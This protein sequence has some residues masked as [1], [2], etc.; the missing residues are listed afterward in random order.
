[1]TE[2]RPTGKS[3]EA[4]RDP[5]PDGG[6]ADDRPGGGGRGGAS[7]A[8]TQS[9]ASGGTTP[10]SSI[11]IDVDDAGEPAVAIEK[12]EEDALRRAAGETEK[13]GPSS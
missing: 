1:M 7:A 10:N 9:R 13:P 12:A 3:D 4:R 8:R 5:L 11:D 2:G 6:P